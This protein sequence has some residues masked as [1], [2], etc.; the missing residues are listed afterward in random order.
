MSEALGARFD[1]YELTM[2]AGDD[3]RVAP[4]IALATGGRVTRAKGRN[5]YAAAWEVSRGDE[6]LAVVYGRSARL[7]EVHVS[8]TG[9]SCD[10]V[11]PIVRRLWPEHRVSR[12][13]GSVDLVADFETVDAHALAFAK[14]RRV[15]HRLVTDSEGGATRYLGA[16]T[17][18]VSVRVYK[19]T[20]QLRALHPERADEI[21]AGLVRYE[22]QVRP[23]KREVKEA[24][25]RMTADDLWGLSAWGRDFA[26][27]ALSIEAERTATHFRRP[28]SWSRS[29]HY[30]AEQYAPSVARRAEEVG[31]A[32]ARAEVLEALGLLS[33]AG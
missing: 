28:S 29:L 15:K 8:I 6:V 4:A 21:P 25:S 16:T 27:E 2:D 5:G 1:W 23:G 24:V 10:E 31:M 20:E 3:E 17:S 11:V 14:G 9:V 19:K 30:L 13:D 22:V 12:A 33:V 18:E 7:G 32:A 26:R